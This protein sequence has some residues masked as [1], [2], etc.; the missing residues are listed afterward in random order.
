MTTLTDLGFSKDAIVETVVSTYDVEGQP[1]AAPMG[2]TMEG[3]GR[4]V[5]RIYTS[6]LTYKNLKA[7]RCAVVNVTSDA[8]VFYRTAFKEANPN[9]GLPL[10][11]FERAETV[12]APRLRTSDAHVEVAVVEEAP[13]DA[14]RVDILCEVKLVKALTVLPKAYCRALCATIEAI[15]HATRVKVFISDSDGQKRE[16]ALKLLDTI[17]ECRAV[18]NRVAPCSR[19][20]E[21][22]ADLTQRADQWRAKAESLR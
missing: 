2:A 22:M 19:Y 8:E 16:Q 10:E 6:S 7:K 20:S 18:V 14:E 1:N 11:W 4:V 5:F 12:D 9:G 3:Y 21:I 17:K 13:F 15:V